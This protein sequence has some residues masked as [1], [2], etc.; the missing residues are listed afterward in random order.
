GRRAPGYE[1]R[2]ADTANVKGLAIVTSSTASEFSQESDDLRASYFSHNLMAGLQGL[3]DSS[4][5]GRITL[6]ELYH[7]AYRR[8]LA[9]TATSPIGGQH[10]TYVYQMSGTGDVVLTK[11]RAADARLRF[12]PEPGATYAVLDDGD[13]VAEV[14]PNTSEAFYLALPA[15]TYRLVRRALAQLSEHTLQLPAGAAVLVRARE[16][17]AVTDAPALARKGGAPGGLVAAADLSARA[18][19]EPE[20]AVAASIT[21]P[22][23][24]ITIGVGAQ[25][26]LLPGEDVAAALSLGYTRTLS[27]HFALRVRGALSRFEVTSPDVPTSRFLRL[28]PQIEI[29][30][31]VFRRDRLRLDAGPLLGAPI[32]RQSAPGEAARLSYGLQYGLASTLALALGSNQNRLL[33]LAV[34]GGGEWFKLDGQRQH[35]KSGA[36][37][38]FGGVAF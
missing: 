15:G 4:G 25:S 20:S 38:L 35:R 24:Q 16:F 36:I 11:T 31:Q 23:N 22:R 12:A 2:L 9:G 1:V 17:T 5:D 27:D 19:D 28:A 21:K 32:V 7:F 10:P 13:V 37:T 18:D 33:G 30:G 8:T 6:S 34:A 3:A 29:A 26:R 14:V